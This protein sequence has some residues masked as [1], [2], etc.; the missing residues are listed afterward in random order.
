MEDKIFKMELG[1]DLSL[2]FI[3]KKFEVFPIS[4]FLNPKTPNLPRSFYF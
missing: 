3:S 1:I 2:W 4:Q